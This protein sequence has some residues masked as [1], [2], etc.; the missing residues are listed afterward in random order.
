MNWIVRVPA[1]IK[2]AKKWLQGSKEQE[3]VED[4]NDKRYKLLSVTS[5]YLGITQRWFIVQSE[6]RRKEGPEE[7]R[8]GYCKKRKRES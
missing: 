1:T 2:E 6:P 8:A 5:D 4:Q 7:I 3:F